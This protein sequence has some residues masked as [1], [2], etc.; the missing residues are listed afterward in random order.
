MLDLLK[1]PFAT[2]NQLRREIDHLFEDFGPR[3]TRGIFSPVRAFPAL[4]IWDDAECVYAEAELPGVCESD[5]EIYAVG[6][7][8]TIKGRREPLKSED[9]PYLQRERDTGEFS[10]VVTLPMEINPDK[11]EAHLHNGILTVK[12]AKTEAEKA[13]KIEVKTA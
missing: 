5:L 13:K 6:N 9:V 4:N 3:L 12:M 11:V 7:E 10:R 8:L 2:M 1:N